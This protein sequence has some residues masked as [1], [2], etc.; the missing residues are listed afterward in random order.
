MSYTYLTAFHINVP[1]LD[2]PLAIDLQGSLRKLWAAGQAF[3]GGG[4]VGRV[5][6]SEA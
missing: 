2:T 3:F 5:G 6:R 4:H 1:R